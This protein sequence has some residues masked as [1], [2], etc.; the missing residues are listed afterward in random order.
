MGI[1]ACPEFA[2]GA[3]I[4]ADDANHFVHFRSDLNTASEANKG[5]VAVASIYEPLRLSARLL[6]ER[7]E[8]RVGDVHSTL[9]AVHAGAE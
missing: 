4:V 2:I 7:L 6:V 8:P 5:S 3:A 9:S 1:R